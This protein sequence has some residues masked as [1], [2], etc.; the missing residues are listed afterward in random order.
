MVFW[1]SECL[2]IAKPN[3]ILLLFSSWRYL[4][5]FSDAVQAA[6]W[7][8][9]SIVVWDKTIKTRPNKGFFRHQAEYIIFG[10]K[11]K[12]TPLNN[13]SLP[14][15][16]SFGV[17]NCE[18]NHITAKPVPLIENLLS[19]FSSKATIID[20]FMGGGSI[21]KACEN[22]GHFYIGIELSPE[23][24]QIAVNFIK[25]KKGLFV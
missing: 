14:G 6:G 13:E 25:E 11:G 5:I 18:K 9:R 16:Y 4:P 21:L 7:V 22:L 19:I 3:G 24:Y 2:R 17:D 20:P 8:W 1:L 12:W 15:V 23:Y 10:T